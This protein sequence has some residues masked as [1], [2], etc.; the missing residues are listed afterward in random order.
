MKFKEYK[1]AL[2]WTDTDTWCWPA[3]DKKLVQVFDHVSDIDHFM[4][5]V[6]DSTLCLQAG[7]ACGVWPLRYA[8]L[9]DTVV[10]F[11]PQPENYHC[12]VEN[13]KGVD[14]IIATHCGLSDNND[15]YSIH[16]DIHERENWGAG[17][18][19][20]DSGG[21][22]TVT[23]DQLDL[24]ACDLIQLDIEGFELKALKGGAETIRKF[25][26]T[27]VLEEKPLNH[28]GGDY[29][30]ARHWLEAE[31]GYKIAAWA[32]RDVILVC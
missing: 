21:I 16:N 5:H 8:Q 24:P 10:T 3:G 19:V 18:L 15:K 17:Y 1:H 30:E 11:E 4:P 22:A 20:P 14:N 2:D 12:L 27:I 13:C 31:Y 25:L 32:H 26:P 6:K 29:A 28:K 7:G 9:F 23:I